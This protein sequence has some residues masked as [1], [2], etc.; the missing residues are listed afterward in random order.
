MNTAQGRW[1]RSASSTSACRS[2][3]PY[4]G[5]G[6]SHSGCGRGKDSQG[7]APETHGPGLP[8]V[9]QPRH[10]ASG[11][12]GRHDGHGQLHEARRAG[13]GDAKRVGVVTTKVGTAAAPGASGVSGPA[14]ERRHRRVDLVA[15]PGQNAGADGV[16]AE[17]PGPVGRRPGPGDP[18]DLGRQRL[19]LG[20]QE[21]GLEMTGI[22]VLAVVLAQAR[23]LRERR[24]GPRVQVGPHLDLAGRSQRPQERRGR[25]DPRRSR[26]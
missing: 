17:A 20:K 19:E 13:A 2:P 14:D 15:E 10:P 4:S 6:R 26:W 22:R 9:A 18:R 11:G 1:A 7:A 3:R 8:V 16:E 24:R 25:A 21:L 12:V 23:L 5:R